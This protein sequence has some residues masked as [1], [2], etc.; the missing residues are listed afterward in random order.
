M[1]AALS[2]ALIVLGA[3]SSAGFG[4]LPLS[5]RMPTCRRSSSASSR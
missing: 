1:R 2:F 5:G 4:I 3:T